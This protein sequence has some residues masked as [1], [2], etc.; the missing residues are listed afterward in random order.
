M[1]SSNPALII[2]PKTVGQSSL[3]T[4]SDVR[5]KINPNGVDFYDVRNA[6]NG[7]VVIECAKSN[8]I[9]KLKEVAMKELSS[10]YSVT[11]PL[12]RQPKVRVIGLHENIPR[13]N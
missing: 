8:D 1:K 6:A 13:M 4:K 3:V 2:K 12:K 10:N 11:A 7:S 9:I 5:A